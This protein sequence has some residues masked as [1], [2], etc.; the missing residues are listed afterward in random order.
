LRNLRRDAALVM[1]A[2]RMFYPSHLATS[3]R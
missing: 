3:V 1:M 2:S